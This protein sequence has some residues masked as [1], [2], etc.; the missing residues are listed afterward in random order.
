MTVRFYNTLA[1]IASR[2][3]VGYD[4][5][6]S[7]MAEILGTIATILQLVDTVLKAREYVKDFRHAPAEQQKLFNEM[8]DLKP[9]LEELEKR[10]AASPSTST[11]QQ[12][13]PPLARFHT[14][15]ESFL[16]KFRPADGQWSKL[17]KQLTWTL[18]NKKESKDYVD[19][20]E[21]I[22]SLITVWLAVE[23]S[24]VGHQQNDILSTVAEHVHA[25][26]VRFSAAEHS[27]ITFDSLEPVNGYCLTRSSKIGSSNQ[28]KSCGFVECRAL[29]KPFF[30]QS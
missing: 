6:Q 7:P 22:K 3:A 5:L 21:N 27:K 17:S 24:D 20:I 14:T 30:H 2:T 18:W 19:E 23:I 25:Q 16:A 12:I 13:T 8:E 10:V 28:I 29:A 15:L 4:F 1:L 26:Q 11:L 9:L